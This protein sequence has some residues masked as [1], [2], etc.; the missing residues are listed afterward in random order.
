MIGENSDMNFAEKLSI[1]PISNHIGTNPVK[2]HG[3]IRYP[4][5]ARRQAM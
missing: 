5:R 1:Y 4:D 3:S 2:C